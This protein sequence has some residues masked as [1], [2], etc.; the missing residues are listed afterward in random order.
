MLGLPVLIQPSEA[1]ENTPEDWTPERIVEELAQRKAKAV[2]D[3]REGADHAVVVGS[4]TLVALDGR[5]LGKPRDEDHAAEMLRMLSGRTHEVYTGLCCIGHARSKT[6]GAGPETIV[7]HTV[8]KVTFRPMS[9]EEIRA[10]VKTGDPLDK[11]GAYG[12][13][14][15]GS[16]FIEKI[17]GDFYSIMGLPMNLLYQ[18]LLKFGVSPFQ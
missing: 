17:E 4:D 12:I 8:S 1:D 6:A 13:Q 9:E 11:A 18:M 10:Y 7:G 16:V 2:W 3:L 15:I 14:G 5:I